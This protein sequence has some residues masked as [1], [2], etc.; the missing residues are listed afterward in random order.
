MR[1]I[2]SVNETERTYAMPA[3]AIDSAPSASPSHPFSPSNRLSC[4]E[5]VQRMVLVAITL[6]HIT[7]RA[8]QNAISLHSKTETYLFQLALPRDSN[9][10]NPNIVMC[11]AARYNKHLPPPIP[12]RSFSAR[13]LGSLFFPLMTPIT[14]WSQGCTGGQI[15]SDLPTTN[16]F[17]DMQQKKSHRFVCLTLQGG[18]R[19]WFKYARCLP[20]L[21]PI[22]TPYSMQF[23]YALATESV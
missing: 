20:A 9:L 18:R 1:W 16:R 8:E 22:R 19:S 12:N 4:L 7:E 6:W 13:D 15:P 2:R 21:N 3:D 14:R 5:P 23:A 17:C 10:R 11:S